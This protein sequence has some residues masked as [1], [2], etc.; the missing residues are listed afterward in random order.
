VAK[1]KP[2]PPPAAPVVAEKPKEPFVV[3]M[4]SGVKKTEAKFTEVK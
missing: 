4:I 3:E 2:A 1:P